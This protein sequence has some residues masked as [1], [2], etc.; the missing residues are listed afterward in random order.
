M[1]INK[2][3]KTKYI[4]II[5]IVI[6]ITII[7]A[8]LSLTANYVF[9][10]NY[11]VPHRMNEDYYL[12]KKYSGH[13]ASDNAIQIIG[14]SVIWGH[15]VSE[16]DTLSAYLNKFS[17][18]KKFAN[19]GLEGIYP[20]A[21]NGLIRN[22][23]MLKDKKIIVGFNLLWISSPKHDLS[24]EPEHN[25]NHKKILPQFYRGIPS[26]KPDIEDRLTAII[27]ISAP[28]LW[29]EHIKMNYFKEK[30]FYAW[31]IENPHNNIMNYFSGNSN[32]IY[33]PPEP[34]RLT[35]ANKQNIEWV[36]IEKSIQWKYLLKTISYLK[37]NG[38]DI[39]VL[40]TPFNTYMLTDQSRDKYYSIISD[41]RKEL[42]GTD[43]N[44][45]IPEIQEKNFFADSSHFT[46]EGYR[47]I[48]TEI[49]G[50]INDF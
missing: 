36:E 2:M 29:I 46:A 26:Y 15:Y 34:M 42:S 7:Y 37:K 44:F 31:T 28:L 23:S 25:I 21:M 32:G 30:N 10:E 22:F 48:A 6:T 47:A 27:S 16:D 13:L 12:F 1:K 9:T 8:M 20:I 33:I 24:G 50:I 18:D 35:Q 3:N 49:Y 14:D 5:L 38:N 19:M 43:I 4:I 11:R 39:I 40:I 17:K 41:I 45:I